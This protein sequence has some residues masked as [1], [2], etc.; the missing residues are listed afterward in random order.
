MTTATSP[1]ISI[2]IATPAD[3][4]AIVQLID[5]AYRGAS[6]LQGWTTESLLIDGQRT[7]LEEVLA[8]MHVATA[9]FLVARLND[10]LVGCCLLDH[11][12]DAAYFGMFA[13]APTLQAHGI[14]ARLLAAAET[15]AAT[16]LAVERLTMSVISIRTE[17]IAWY[18]RRGYQP[19]GEQQPFPYGNPRAGLPRRDDLTFTV[20]EKQLV[21][22]SAS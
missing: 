11:Q 9:R 1:S 10:A 8:C 21:P 18:Q 5:S 6:G 4:P 7:D 14:G 16:E 15:F 19:T 17:L 13:V 2:E 22:M 12:D 20:F 3:A